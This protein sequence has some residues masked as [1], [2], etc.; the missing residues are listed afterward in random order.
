M[1]RR[2]HEQQ[3]APETVPASYV[4]LGCGRGRDVSAVH[5]WYGVP[6]L[7]LDVHP[8]AFRK[9]ER[10]QA[11]DEAV[12]FWTFNL[13]E[14]RHHGVV[15]A[16]A[17]LALP[18]PRLV[19]ARHLVDAI[20]ADGEPVTRLAELA[21]TL[22]GDGA[23]RLHV[24]FLATW[25]SDSY[26]EELR[27]ATALDPEAV[28][29]TLERA[30]ARVLARELHPVSDAPGASVTCHLIADWPAHPTGGNPS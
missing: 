13:L 17:G 25:G 14:R 2:I 3:S 19:T 10:R 22:L 5:Q 27:L 20:E 6:A 11:D 29:V 30:G 4:D 23:G 24:E 26:P 8:H 12:R 16:Y 21:H 1:L 7:G 15:A 28:A 18:E 9:H